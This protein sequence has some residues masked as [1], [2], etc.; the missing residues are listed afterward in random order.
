MEGQKLP[1]ASRVIRSQVPG[2][3]G[4]NM[5]VGEWQH[6]VRQGVRRMVVR[7]EQG[8]VGSVSRGEWGKLDKY[9]VITAWN[10]LG[11]KNKNKMGRKRGKA[12]GCYIR[13]GCRGQ[14]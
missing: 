2:E 6:E 3:G 10:F 1:E 12:A 7:R 11:K 5:E 13:A 14:C 8:A 4:K 9:D